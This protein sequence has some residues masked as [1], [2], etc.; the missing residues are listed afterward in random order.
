MSGNSFGELFRI[1]TFGESHGPAVGV[2]IDGVPP[3]I[4]ITAEEINREL[5]RRRPGQ[6]HL[7]TQRKEPDEC[8]I[9]S[10]VSKGVT[11]GTPIGVIVRNMDARPDAYDTMRDVYRPSHADF[12]YDT[13]YGIKAASGGGR[14]SA[15]ETIARVIGGALARK[16]LATFSPVEIVGWV[17]KV[18]DIEVTV[19]S[20]K[21]TLDEVEANPVRC[22]DPETARRMEE[23][24]DEVRKAGDSIGGVVECVIRNVPAGW[25]MPVFDKAEALLGAAMLSIPAAKGV[26]IGSGFTGTDLRGSTHNDAF[27][28][29]AGGI[30]TRTNR[31]GGIQGGITNGEDIVIRVA[32]KPTSTIMIEQDSVNRDGEPVKIKGKG[33]HDPCVLP[34]AVP[35]VEAMAAL[36]LADLALR[37]RAQCGGL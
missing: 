33:R 10:G 32:F 15:R 28:P 14:A 13:K 31:S 20:S 29:K 17:A 7:V 19:D 24:I 36:V 35:I 21:V 11:L 26:E 4:E 1:T 2:V 25:G 27:I 5:A 34:R 16:I 18:E 37:H 12:T 30:G 23:R 3:R 6:S 9:L 22:P 8:E